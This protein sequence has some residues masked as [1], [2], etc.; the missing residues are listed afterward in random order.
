M[1]NQNLKPFKKGDPRCWRQGRPK[2]FSGLREL[3]QRIGDE[4]ARDK[5]GNPIIIH[6][7]LPDEHMATTV[8]MIA[9][10]QT[11]DPK[12]Q[13]DFI[14]YGYGKVPNPVEIAGKDGG[15]VEITILEVIK[16]KENSE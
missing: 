15:A 1:N 3:Y 6:Q 14:E 4:I 9:R 8:E 13:R 11:R 12:R 2:G 7:G 10:Q 5:D 16:D